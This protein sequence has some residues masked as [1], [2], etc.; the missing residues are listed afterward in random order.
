MF[1]GRSIISLAKLVIRIDSE[2]FRSYVMLYKLW[3]IKTKA[4]FGSSKAT[5]TAQS[6][7]GDREHCIET[8]MDDYISK[9]VTLD[10]LCVA[11]ERWILAG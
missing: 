3:A 5:M 1:H 4:S 6:M 2:G 9:P 8:G 7:P 11:V 10:A